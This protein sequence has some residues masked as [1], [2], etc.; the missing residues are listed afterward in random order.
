[1]V[2]LNHLLSLLGI[3][4]ILVLSG[5]NNQIDAPHFIWNDILYIA[6]YEPISDEEIIEEIGIISE[7]VG[8]TAEESGEAKGIAQ[9]TRLYR[10]KGREVS[11][12]KL[13]LLHMK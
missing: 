9:G 6:T 10:I 13:V 11:S 12:G 8:G 2:K 7:V 3:V 5:C 1:M 4:I